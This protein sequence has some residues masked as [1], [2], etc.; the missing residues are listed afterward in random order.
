MGIVVD[1][2]P[3]CSKIKVGD[4]V[5]IIPLIECNEC[6]YCKL[7]KPNLCINRKVIGFQT[8]G[9]LAEEIIIPIENLIVLSDECGDIEGTLLEPVAVAVHSTNLI[10]KLKPYSRDVIITGAGT[11]GLMIG[12]LLREFKGYNITIIEINKDRI[13]LAKQLGFNVLKNLNEYKSPDGRRPITFECTGNL[14]VFEKSKE[15]VP[16]PEVM[17]ILGTFPREVQT[18]IFHMC[19]YETLFIGSQMYTKG[20]LIQAAKL[21]STPLKEVVKGIVANRIYG[22]NEINEAFEEALFSKNGTKVIVS[23]EKT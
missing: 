16:S 14:E 21:L 17:V 15:I 10:K 13:T 19:K 11:I 4:R 7:E 5:A 1:V 22:L 3:I 8:T 2:N 20:D 12:L 6:E 23:M 18:S 9:C